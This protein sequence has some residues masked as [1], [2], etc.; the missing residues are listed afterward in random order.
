MDDKRSPVNSVLRRGTIGLGAV[1]GASAAIGAPMAGASLARTSATATAPQKTVSTSPLAPRDCPD[2]LCT[3]DGDPFLLENAG[4]PTSNPSDAV[5]VYA[6]NIT[7]SAGTDV[8]DVVLQYSPSAR[9]VRAVASCIGS[10]A[11]VGA[12]VFKPRTNQVTS[13]DYAPCG[14][15]AVT[16]WVNDNGIAQLAIGRKIQNGR[17]LGYAETPPY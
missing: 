1:L 16:A 13:S 14:S 17:W 4:C 8:G 11:G 12:L 7:N 5:Q 3:G 2:Q 6:R 9:C 10:S 15:K